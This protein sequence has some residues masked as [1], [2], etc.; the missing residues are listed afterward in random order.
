MDISMPGMSG[1]DA[2][3]ML[4]FTHEADSLPPIVALSADGTAETRETC[5]TVGF[6][7]YLLKPVEANLLLDTLDRLTGSAAPPAA[8]AA[9]EAPAAAAEPAR[10]ELAVLDRAK[11]ERLLEL[12]PT[13]AFV[14][15]LIDDFVTDAE[16]ILRRLDAARAAADPRAMRDHAHALRSS[17]AHLGSIDLFQRCLRWR[18]LDDNAL[19]MRGAA[20][21]DA[22]RR[23]FAALVKELRAFQGELKAR[24]PRG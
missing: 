1:I 7:E 20:E 14:D 6:S 16:E 21:L 11:L 23:S 5:R 8:G 4:R 24:A 17:A 19:V 13:S 22:V 10:D 15:E 3:K 2:V 18:D 12:D 9:A